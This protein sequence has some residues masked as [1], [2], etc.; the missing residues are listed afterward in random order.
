MV[1]VTGLQIKSKFFNL[2]S[3][4]P[5]GKQANTE[6]LDYLESQYLLR[7]CY[8]PG[9]ARLSRLSVYIIPI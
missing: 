5:L 1:A 2:L 8:G 7:A 3:S 9:Q 6:L 4:Q